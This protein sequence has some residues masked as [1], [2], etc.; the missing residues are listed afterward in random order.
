[1]KLKPARR[2]GYGIISI[3]FGRGRPLTYKDFEFEY[4]RAL[5][6]IEKV[7][8]V[9]IK[10]D[11]VGDDYLSFVTDDKVLIPGH[12]TKKAIGIDLG[13][14]TPA[15]SCNGK[16]IFEDIMPILKRYDDK[17][18]SLR[19]YRGK[20]ESK[21][22]RRLKRLGVKNPETK[23]KNSR[24]IRELSTKILRLQRKRRRVFDDWAWNKA[25]WICQKYDYICMQEDYIPGWYKLWGKQLG[26]NAIGDF[27]QKLKWQ[28]AKMGKTYCPVDKWEKTS[29]KCSRC[30]KEKV[31]PPD[32][33]AKEKLKQLKERVFVCDHCGFEIDR[34]HNGAVNAKKLA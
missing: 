15:V 13:V 27:R 14:G 12:K 10:R 20:L 4:H 33:D 22:I 29:Q 17:I 1:M 3:G 8:S 34:D 9:T 16:N 5:P 11:K 32:V 21:N 24:A 23:G 25:K 2:D 18:D 19:E 7:T 30:E 28:A 31:F 26:R 6:P